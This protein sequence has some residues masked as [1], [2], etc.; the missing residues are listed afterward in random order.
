MI[1]TVFCVVLMVCCTA[2]AEEAPLWLVVGRPGLVEA[3]EPLAE[4]RRAEGF[5]TEISTDGIEEAIADARGLRYLL[6]VGD[7]EAGKESESWYLPSRSVPF[8]R[9]SKRLAETFTSD[10]VWGDLDD[11]GLPD[12][13]VGRI[14]ARNRKEV[15]IVVSK[16]LAYEHREL[17]EKDLRLIAWAG[18]ARRGPA[19]D[20]LISGLLVDTIQKNAADWMQPW[21]VA[22]DKRHPLC[23]WPEEQPEIFTK[24]MREGGFLAT[25][26]GHARITR[27][28]VMSYDGTSIG[29]TAEVAAPLLADGPPT[30]MLVFYACWAGNFM[31]DKQ[32]LSESFLFMPSG[33]V[34]VIGATIESHPIPNTYSGVALLRALGGK[35]RRVGDVWLAAQRDMLD[36]H[37]PLMDY[38]ISL[39]KE[40]GAKMDIDRLKR[41]HFLMYAVFGDPATRMPLPEPLDATIERTDSGWRWKAEKPKGATRI[42]A[43]LRPRTPLFSLLFKER[44]EDELRKDQQQANAKY[45]FTPLPSPESGEPWEGTVSEP[46]RLRL[47]ASGPGVLNVATFDLKEDAP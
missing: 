15:E 35:E 31:A 28:S 4:A 6:L 10:L 46:G 13:P 41:D 1:R 30:P 19:I 25:F 39:S 7:A 2:A 14:P 3:V 16:I 9:W 18:E 34:A 43:G 32:V 42:H 44:N 29:Y 26:M 36:D 45:E 24:Q 27:C 38:L 23:G 12:I 17:S 33:P 37:D 20:P 22:S 40:E 21:V 47:V 8:Y 11:D 5:R